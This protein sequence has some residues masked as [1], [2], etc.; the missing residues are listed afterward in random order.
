MQL[1][2]G[3]N[4]FLLCFEYMAVILYTSYFFIDVFFF[5]EQSEL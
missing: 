1:S 3:E 2:S 4:L 5:K